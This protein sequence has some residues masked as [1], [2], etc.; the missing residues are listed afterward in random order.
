[1]VAEELVF[2]ARQSN[3]TARFCALN[4]ETGTVVWESNKF[5]PVWVA[6][7]YR[8]GML[9][10]GNKR[11]DMFGVRASSGETVWSYYTMKDTP[12]E[13]KSTDV[14]P[15]HGW[16]PGVYSNPA[17]DDE[18]VYV[19][20]WSGFYFAFDQS[21]GALVWRTATTGK[22][23]GGR[24][25][26]QR[27]FFIR[28]ICMFRNKAPTSRPF[29]KTVV[30]S[31]GNGKLRQASCRMVSIAAHGDRIYG[32][33]V[34]GVTL[35]PYHATIVAF[36]DVENGGDKVWEYDGGGGLTAPV[37]TDDSVIFG[38]SA[39]MFMTGLDANSGSL[40]WRT[41]TGGVMLENVPTI[42]GARAYAH[43]K[44]GW[45]LAVE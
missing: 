44:N 33:V 38:S 32:S 24:P 1:M 35:L 10:F 20:S 21:T 17:M 16:P 4:Q 9:F 40:V 26:L 2:V 3:R 43:F 30:I 12:L 18:K 22:G 19:G 45:V 14:S 6:P 23:E 7:V 13:D 8:N 15:S 34:R 11:G 29:T 27:Q 39:D 42:Y 5:G 28:I 41:F 37:I 31:C 25:D 36:N